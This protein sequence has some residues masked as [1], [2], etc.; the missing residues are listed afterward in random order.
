MILVCE[1]TYKGSS[2]VHRRTQDPTTRI[3]DTRHSWYVL[4]ECRFFLGGRYPRTKGILLW[5]RKGH[6]ETLC[7]RG[8]KVMDVF[9]KG[10][11]GDSN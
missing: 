3:R 2:R 10:R 11:N 5:K 9:V 1:E 6:R 7:D 8:R 4:H